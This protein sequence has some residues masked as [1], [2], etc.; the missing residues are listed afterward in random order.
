MITVRFAPVPSGNLHPGGLR[1]F[2]INWLFAK[3]NNGRFILRFEDT[4]PRISFSE[5]RDSLLRTFHWLGFDE[6]FEVMNQG[7][8]HHIYKK[9]AM[10]LVRLG[11]AYPCFCTRNELLHRLTDKGFPSS[12]EMVSYDGFCMNLTTDEIATRLSAGLRPAYRLKVEPQVIFMEDIIKGQVR[13]DTGLMGD[14][15]ILR[16]DG[17]GLYNFA[18]VVDDILTGVTHV[19]RGEDHLVNTPK[20]ML[21]YQALEAPPPQFAHIPLFLGDKG[22]KYSKRTASLSIFQL[23]KQGFL[24][25]AIL[26]YIFY[27][28]RKNVKERPILTCDEMIEQS[29]LSKI[30]SSYCR[31]DMKQLKFFNRQ[32]IKKRSD[33]SIESDILDFL[34]ERGILKERPE[35]EKLEALR[36]L[37]PDMQK[38]CHDMAELSLAYYAVMSDMSMTNPLTTYQTS[39]LTTPQSAT[40]SPLAAPISPVVTPLSPPAEP[41][42]GTEEARSVPATPPS[43]LTS[44]PRKDRFEDSPALQ[45]GGNEAYNH[46]ISTVSTVFRDPAEKTF[47]Y[48]SGNQTGIGGKSPVIAE[49]KGEANDPTDGL[50]A[51]LRAAATGTLVDLNTFRQFILSHRKRYGRMIRKAITG[52]TNGIPLETLLNLPDSLLREKIERLFNAL[53][54][55]NA[56]PIFTLNKREIEENRIRHYFRKLLGF[57]VEKIEKLRGLRNNSF[58]V[59]CREGSFVFKRALT[60]DFSSLHYEKEVMLRVGEEGLSPHSPLMDLSGEFFNEPVLVYAWLSG[61]VPEVI[62]PAL[63]QG[64]TEYLCRIHAV[65]IPSLPFMSTDSLRNY[66]DEFMENFRNYM[67]LR[68]LEG[69]GEDVFTGTLKKYISIIDDHIAKYAGYWRNKFPLSLLH[70]DLRPSNI[71][72]TEAGEKGE[73]DEE[74]DSDGAGNREGRPEGLHYVVRQPLKTGGC[75]IAAIDWEEAR[76]GDPAFEISW[77]FRTNN[78]TAQQERK[79]RGIYLNLYHK[80]FPADKYIAERIEGYNLIN[81]LNFPLGSAIHCMELITGS[82]SIS[83]P[84]PY[85]VRQEGESLERGFA[86]AFKRVDAIVYKD[87]EN[88]EIEEDAGKRSF[89]FAQDDRESSFDFAQDYRKRSFDFAQDDRESSFDFAQDYRKRSCDIAQDGRKE[90]FGFAQADGKGRI[91]LIPPEIPEN[92]I[93]VIDGVSS[94]GKSIIAPEIAGRMDLLYINLGAFFRAVVFELNRQN[95]K[96]DDIRLP[97]EIKKLTINYRHITTPPF[98]RISINGKDISSYLYT[99]ETETKVPL[100]SGNRFLIDF[101]K[102]KIKTINITTKGTVIEGHKAGIEFFPEAQFKFFLCLEDGERAKLKRD[103]LSDPENEDETPDEETVSEM[104][105]ARDQLDFSGLPEDR[106]DSY[107]TI[108]MEILDVGKAVREIFDGLTEILHE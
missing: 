6:Q 60:G 3:K 108:Q 102:D 106:L 17:T 59:D 47:L 35:P 100:Y 58:R 34:D 22:E 104:L 63:Y 53:K 50:T 25:E 21:I 75:K 43:L 82:K 94:S 87:T 92:S 56:P 84:I 40:F 7:E 42:S 30:S 71:V 13:F 78:F 62:E 19:I 97:N 86:E 85:Y 18:C 11:R 1:V 5:Y 36:G 105:E 95:I 48:N 80:T 16:N 26:N 90:S 76:L 38:R 103:Q 89:D 73:A 68:T 10:E 15:I 101:I 70:G 57:N 61:R 33:E 67:E 99:T 20:Q 31:F 66:F 52:S 37:L 8:R 55:G 83:M 27:T 14:F 45:C 69:L 51:G 93:I 107:K 65:V 96:P 81:H 98:F 88:G 77:F 28:G 44:G 23:K 41:F 54:T 39:H 46:I 79:F 2:L 64:I 91:F 74:A 4:D 12:G 49:G 32:A 72:V 29:D 9:A 24:P